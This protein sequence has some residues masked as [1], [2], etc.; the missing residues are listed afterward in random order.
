MAIDN[1]IPELSL[2]Q[3]NTLEELRRRERELADFIENASV[4]LHWVGPDGTILWANQAELDLLGHTREEYIGHHIAEFHADG[5]VISDILCRL[6]NKETLHNYEARLRCKD[7]SV[8]H[9]LINSNVMWEGDKFI[10]TRCFTRDITGRKEAEERLARSEE[11]LALAQAAGNIGTFDWDIR[12]DAVVW[13]EEL[14]SLFGLPPGG[15]GGTFQNWRERVHPE[16][17]TTCEATIRE[18]IQGKA[19]DWQAEYRMYRADIGEMR[20]VNAKSRIFYDHT[21]APLRMIGINIDVTD[22]KRAEQILRKQQ[23]DYQT[24][25]DSVPAMIWYKDKENRHLRCNRRAAEFIGLSVGEVEGTSAW[26][27][28]QHEDAERFYAE[29]MEVINSGRPKVGLI[30]LLKTPSGDHRWHQTDKIPYF[31]QNRNIAGVVIVSSDITRQ[32]LSQSRLATQY[33]ITMILAEAATVEEAT[34]NLIQAI[35]ESLGWDLGELWRV[36]PD[37]ESLRCSGGWHSP[38]VAED[39]YADMCNSHALLR[40]VGL[41]GRVWS[42]GESVWI[43]DVTK[44]ENFPRAKVAS[45]GGLR[46]AF[47]F[48]IRAGQEMAGVMEFFSREVRERQ[49]E[50]IEMISTL[51][52]QIGQFIERKDAEEALRESEESYRTLAQTASD[53]IITIDEAST[54]MF[55]NPAVEKVFGYPAHELKGQQITLLMPDYLRRLH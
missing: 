10:H 15:F 33:S 51:G 27:L 54:I 35:C 34:P 25:L 38:S 22:H 41:P 1:V 23:E 32:K 13:T 30:E 20:W 52:S 44:D 16:D 42:C 29:D 4:G 28:F 37:E 46:S 14:E 48:P 24:I 31:D 49:A 12:T 43:S 50:V 26:D 6:T 17:L 19:S 11:R 3:S 40:G 7:G 53:A 45:R 36:C 21:G 5:D 18:A 39:V 2:E 55:A 47:A 9:V 8:R